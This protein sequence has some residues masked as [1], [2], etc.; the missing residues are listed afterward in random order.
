[1]IYM[2]NVVGDVYN[3]AQLPRKT[4]AELWQCVRNLQLDRLP[5]R[6]SHQP[7]F[8]GPY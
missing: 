3:V 8:W 4:T 7:R 5:P 2:E 6:S 1:M